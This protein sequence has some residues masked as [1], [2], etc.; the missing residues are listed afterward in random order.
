MKKTLL[1]SVVA[2][3]MIMAGGD[4]APVEPVVAAPAATPVAAS[5]WDFNGQAALYYQTRD[6]AN[7]DLFAKETALGAAGLQVQGTNKNVWNGVG[8]GFEMTGM[9]DLYLAP[10]VVSGFMQN[11]NNNVVAPGSDLLNNRATTDSGAEITQAYLTYG[12]GNTSIKLGRQALPKSLSP[13]AFSEGWNV[14]KNTYDAALVVNTDLPDTTL[15]LADVK[16][17]NYITN[18]GAFNQVNKNDGAYMLTAQN[19]SIADLT[20]TGSVYYLPNF[21]TVA[22]NDDATIAWADAKYKMG[23]IAVALQ[24][25]TVMGDAVT[26]NAENTVAFGAKVGGN[27]SGIDASL[28][29]SNVNDGQAGVFNAGGVKTPLYTQMILNQGA[30]RKDNDTVVARVGTAALGGKVGL[31]VDYTKSNATGVED[32]TEA[33]LTYKTKVFNNTTTLFAGYVYTQQDGVNNDD[34]Q[35]MIRVWGRYNF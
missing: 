13:F 10:E 30:I 32:Y 22:D 9:S 7:D 14:F 5:N 19:K 1:L 12:I 4:I 2:S 6:N 21:F 18:L 24:G 23:D 25:G 28:A 27:F 17:A 34:A 29:Y 20:L 11:I 31:A 3:T 26:A 15:V 35:N 8:A 16:G 33:D